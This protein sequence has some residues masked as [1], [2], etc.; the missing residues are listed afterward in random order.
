MQRNLNRF[1]LCSISLLCQLVGWKKTGLD[2]L[3]DQC[4]IHWPLKVWRSSANTHTVSF[5]HN[6]FSVHNKCKIANVYLRIWIT[7]SKNIMVFNGFIQETTTSIFNCR[8][9]YIYYYSVKKAQ[10]SWDKCKC[11]LMGSLHLLQLTLNTHNSHDAWARTAQDLQ[12]DK[13]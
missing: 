5:I 8:Y 12:Y 13:G 9:D 10:C 7:L 11:N 6:H 1:F 3:K 4:I 2:K